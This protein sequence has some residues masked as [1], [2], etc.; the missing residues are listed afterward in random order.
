MSQ[1]RTNKEDPHRTVASLGFLAVLW[2]A[3]RLEAEARVP[4]DAEDVLKDVLDWAL[5][6]SLGWGLADGQRN[7]P[8]MYAVSSGKL[9][10]V[11]LM[12]EGG[13]DFRVRNTA[14]D[15]ALSKA[16]AN[17]HFSIATTILNK[18]R[19]AGKLTHDYLQHAL[20]LAS[21]LR[22]ENFI[23]LL[24][25][26]GAGIKDGLDES[27]TGQVGSSGNGPEMEPVGPATAEG[28]TGAEDTEQ[29]ADSL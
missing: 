3:S 23:R 26:H 15:T 12:L 2:A 17:D 29:P 28:Q 19:R 9:A 11:D 7:T 25:Q 27:D 18:G 5:A 6:S 16:V 10:V 4:G 22:K 1:S 24:Q 21:R 13:V 14:G 8:L 20:S